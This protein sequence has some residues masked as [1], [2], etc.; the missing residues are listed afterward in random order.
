MPQAFAEE[1]YFLQKQFQGYNLILP[2][3]L[4]A[5]GNCPGDF[6]CSGA[7]TSNPWPCRSWT[8]LDIYSLLF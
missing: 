1:N 3:N 7:N 5:F 4:K 8:L 2:S 6:I